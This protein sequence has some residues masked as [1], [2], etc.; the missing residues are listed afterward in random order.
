MEAEVR[1]PATP[2]VDWGLHTPPEAEHSL[3]KEPGNAI[4]KLGYASVCLPL[5]IP[6]RENERGWMKDV[7]MEGEIP[8][9]NWGT[10]C[11]EHFKARA[12]SNKYVPA[13][14]L[15][16]PCEQNS[17]PTPMKILPC[18]KL[19]LRAVKRRYSSRM[20]TAR[21]SGHHEMYAPRGRGSSSEQAWTVL[22]WR[23]PDVTSTGRVCPEGDGYV[24]RGMGM[25]GGV[26]RGLWKHYLPATTVAGRTTFRFRVS[27]QDFISVNGPYAVIIWRLLNMICIKFGSVV[28][29]TLLLS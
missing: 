27:G 26:D 13:R 1:L 6:E 29:Q 5:K 23:S 9:H 4:G 10:V 20:R 28:H 7:K 19:R 25:S 2:G 3:K 12:V 8:L 16:P 17:W 18:P 21:S 14:V 22:Q 11:Y 15:P 24:Q